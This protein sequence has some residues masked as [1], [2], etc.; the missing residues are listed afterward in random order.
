MQRKKD[1]YTYHKKLS[2]KETKGPIRVTM[3]KS[4]MLIKP[5]IT[6]EEVGTMFDCTYVWCNYLGN[7]L[8]DYSRYST[9]IND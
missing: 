2:W 1:P 3:G 8:G 9:Y 4:C 6:E 7:C 5:H